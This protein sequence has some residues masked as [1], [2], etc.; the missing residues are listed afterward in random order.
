LGGLDL[1]LG[2]LDLCLVVQEQR[3]RLFDPSH[4]RQAQSVRVRVPTSSVAERQP[5]ALG[6]RFNLCA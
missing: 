2:G 5:D 1:C 6:P 4:R 3:R